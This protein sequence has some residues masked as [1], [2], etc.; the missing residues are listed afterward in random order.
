MPIGLSCCTDYHT[1][2]AAAAVLGKDS[3]S[4]WGIKPGVLAAHH[5]HCFFEFAGSG[6]GHNGRYMQVMARQISAGHAGTDTLT[7]PAVVQSSGHVHWGT[8]V[9]V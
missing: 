3:H 1:T 9:V 7:T 8:A 2:S 4:V 6:R 5:G